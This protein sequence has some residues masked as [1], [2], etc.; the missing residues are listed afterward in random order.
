MKEP[1]R[2]LLIYD[3]LCQDP[4][5]RAKLRQMKRSFLTGAK[6]AMV[7]NQPGTMGRDTL[8]TLKDVYL[9]CRTER[10]PESLF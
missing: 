10:E 3:S 4:L 1:G 8:A 9:N 6:V 5:N 7:C 2:K